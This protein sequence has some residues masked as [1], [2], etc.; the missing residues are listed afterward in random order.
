MN[1][2]ESGFWPQPGLLIGIAIGVFCL[3][4][5]PELSEKKDLG[6]NQ[7][8]DSLAISAV[9]KARAEAF[10]QGN[11]AGIALHF[12][13]NSLLMAPDKQVQR[14]R[15]AVE[16]YY[17]QLF[18]TWKTDLRSEY[19]E[20]KVSGNLAYGRGF[21]EVTLIPKSGGDTLKSTAK[22]LNILERQPDGS[23]KTTHD[24]WNANEPSGK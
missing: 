10:R 5:D 18:D 14:G 9:S 7:E 17:Q 1:S 8:N 13:E 15:V 11:A 24:I 3:S 20:V 23:W 12:T 6:E 16:A 21:A 22:Y 4:C 2:V 19:L